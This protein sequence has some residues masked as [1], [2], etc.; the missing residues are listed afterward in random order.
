MTAPN[1]SNPP[2]AGKQLR[3]LKARR[4]ALSAEITQLKTR[5]QEMKAAGKGGQE[6]QA[7]R[8]RLQQLRSEREQLVQHAKSLKA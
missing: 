5:L 7:I 6:R 4:D 3:D 1:T 2:S 8:T